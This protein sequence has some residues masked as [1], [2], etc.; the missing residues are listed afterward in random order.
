MMIDAVSADWM[1]YIRQSDGFMTI[2][3]LVARTDDHTRLYTSGVRNT[4]SKFL[5]S[6]VSLMRW[7]CIIP[8]AA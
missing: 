2:A 6:A 7:L 1:L 3:V 5:S 8:P 4:N